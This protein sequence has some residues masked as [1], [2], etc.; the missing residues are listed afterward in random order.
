MGVRIFQLAKE[1]GMSS[2][3][4]MEYLRTQ[5]HQISN[6]M[7]SVEDSVATILKDRLPRPSSGQTKKNAKAKPAEKAA[8]GGTATATAEAKTR[9]AKDGS[10]KPTSSKKVDSSRTD[11]TRKGRGGRAGVAVAEKPKTLGRTDRTRRSGEGRAPTAADKDK[12]KPRPK[13]PASGL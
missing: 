3:D 6:H 13:P 7:S 9:R 2:K 5:G 1:L 10:S 8:N 4:L 11:T 12:S